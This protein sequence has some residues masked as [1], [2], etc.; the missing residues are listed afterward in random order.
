MDAISF[1]DDKVFP[2]SS[3]ERLRK[4]CQ[5]WPSAGGRQAPRAAGGLDQHPHCRPPSSWPHGRG[6][7]M[8]D[9]EFHPGTSMEHLPHARLWSFRCDSD[10]T[11]AIKGFTKQC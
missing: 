7:L 11:P 4:D 8:L 5:R 6:N 10:M 9:I 1:M 3:P 2:I